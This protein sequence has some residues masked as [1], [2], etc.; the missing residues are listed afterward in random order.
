V[1]C[2]QA[3]AAQGVLDRDPEWARDPLQ[4][5]QDGAR[6]GVKSHVNRLSKLDLRDRT[7]AAVRAYESGLVEPGDAKRSS[8]G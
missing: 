5:I 6:G 8:S 2:L 4:S 3:G 7:Q 1:I